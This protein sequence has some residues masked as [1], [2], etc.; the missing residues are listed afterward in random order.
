M[1][2]IHRLRPAALVAPVVSIAL[3]MSACTTP[4]MQPSAPGMPEITTQERRELSPQL[5]S[6]ADTLT[7]MATLQDRLYRVAAPLL[8]DNAELCKA[9]ARNLLGFTAKN[10]Y[11]YPGEYN[12]AAAPRASACAP[13][14]AWSPPAASR[15]PP[16]PTRFPAPARYSPR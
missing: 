4:P 16:V 14:T 7:R 2:R 6:A 11:A 12:Q 3:L 1:D 9:N 10:R 15:C 8:I 13:A 5:A